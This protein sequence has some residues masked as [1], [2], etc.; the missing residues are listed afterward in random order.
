M[1]LKHVFCCATQTNAS[2]RHFIW[3][4]K[5]QFFLVS[6]SLPIFSLRS[7]QVND[8]VMTNLCSNF[9]C[10]RQPCCL[11]D[12]ACV[13]STV[14][15]V[16][17]LTTCLMRSDTKLDTLL[18]T[19]HLEAWKLGCSVMYYD[20]FRGCTT[21]LYIKILV[22]FLDEI[23]FYAAI[24]KWHPWPSLVVVGLFRNCLLWKTEL[25]M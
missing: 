22:C 3:G 11:E 19:P 9:W 4:S 21:A 18:H 7:Y 17:M 20:V 12:C 14:T 10:W 6:D 8:M 13:T 25:A 16:L 1:P 23:S 2:W 24:Q 15:C 5:R